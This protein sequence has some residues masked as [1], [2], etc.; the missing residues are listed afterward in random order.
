MGIASPTVGVEGRERAVPVWDPL[1]RA[2]H[3]TLVLAFAVAYLSGDEALALHVRAGYAIGGLVLSRVVWGFVGPRHARFSDFVRGPLASWGYLLDLI[4][5]RARRHLGH[6][7]AGGAMVLALLAGLALTV[8]TGLQLYAVE[9][10]AG[11][12]ATL[13]APALVG[14]ATAAEEATGDGS[15]EGREAG[16]ESVWG[17]LHELLADLVLALVVLHVGGVALA[18]VA[19][20]ENLVRAMVTGR[21]RAV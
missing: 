7:P 21:K 18:S 2:F 9:K 8:G 5:F 16:G 20:S 3:W 10:H 12:L 19:H 1:V 6:S 11:P 13:A 15:G 14:S 17:G 4:R